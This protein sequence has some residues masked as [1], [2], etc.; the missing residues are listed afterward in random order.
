[1]AFFVKMLRSRVI[2]LWALLKL[3]VRRIRGER[4]NV[5]M[6]LELLGRESLY[7]PP[8]KLWSY[9]HTAGGC[10]GC[11]LCDRF[12]KEHERPA[13]WLLGDAREPS[14]AALANVAAT[15]LVALE[16]DVSEVCPRRVNLGNAGRLL[17][18][19]QECVRVV[20]ADTQDHDTRTTHGAKR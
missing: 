17:R 4:A 18:E 3:W 10:I 11:G 19:N 2:L 16:G 13:H 14:T 5:E 7:P 20:D 1:V 9:A 8:P 12:G 15:R 6:W